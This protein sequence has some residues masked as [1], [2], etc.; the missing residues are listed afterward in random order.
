MRPF[1]KISTVTHHFKQA[2]FGPIVKVS[3]TTLSETQESVGHNDPPA[4]TSSGRSESHLYIVKEF[5]DKQV[6]IHKDDPRW[7]FSVPDEY[8]PNAFH[9]DFLAMYK[10]GKWHE[11]GYEKRQ[12]P[13]AEAVE[14]GQ[15]ELLGFDRISQSNFMFDMN[16]VIIPCKFAFGYIGGGLTNIKYRMK[17]LFA[18]LHRNPQVE[19]AKIVEIPYYNR[20]SGS[21]AIEFVYA[22][23]AEEFAAHHKNPRGVLKILEVDKFAKD[24]DD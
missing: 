13:V 19:D 20:D 14:S 16:N 12:I 9:P 21:H 7:L 6:E 23:T 18:H 22:P 3:I 8:L 4:W 5:F 24:E 17:S 1:T 15:F 11:Y 2:V 10:A